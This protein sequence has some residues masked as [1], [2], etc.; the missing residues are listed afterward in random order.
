MNNKEMARHYK[1]KRQVLLK[2]VEENNPD[3]IPGRKFVFYS[4]ATVVILM[5]INL[6]LGIS[7]HIKY[8]FPL[9]PNGLVVLVWP[10]LL[11]LIF[12]RLI[13]S[14]GSKLFI[15]FL[16]LGGITGLYIAYINDVFLFLNTENILLNVISIFTILAGLIQIVSM[17]F[18]LL[19]IKCKTYFRL[20]LDL[21]KKI[22][23]ELKSAN[24][25]I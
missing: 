20:K 7:F 3:F 17:V 19:N 21:N 25:T 22:S 15:Y 2:E 4:L 11:S 13:Y 10:P 23:D 1:E 16:L 18:I 9:T 8:D 5:L 12:A 14:L 6:V 24:G